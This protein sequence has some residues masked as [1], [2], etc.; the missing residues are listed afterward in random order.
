MALLFVPNRR[1]TK[2]SPFKTLDTMQ[3]A[4]GLDFN[5]VIAVARELNER[6]SA[7]GQKR[8]FTLSNTQT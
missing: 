1:E 5:D 8:T 2:R 7:L 4:P 3:I 6:L